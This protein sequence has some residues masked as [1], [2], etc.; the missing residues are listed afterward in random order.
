[1]VLGAGRGQ[2]PAGICGNGGDPGELGVLL[3][4]VPEAGPGQGNPLEF[5]TDTPARQGIPG[6][7][8]FPSLLFHFL[9]LILHVNRI[10][11]CLE[12]ELLSEGKQPRSAEGGL[13]GNM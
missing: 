8:P 3:L 2:V 1:M 7:R 6:S 4:P 11:L 13:P 9:D 12:K 5:P 10:D